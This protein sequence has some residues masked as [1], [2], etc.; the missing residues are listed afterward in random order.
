LGKA[1]TY[2]RMW[3]LKLATL[4]TIRA[5]CVIDVGSRHFDFTSLKGT[6][7]ELVLAPLDFKFTFCQ[8]ATAPCDGQKTS[9]C[10]F[11][12]TRHRN[13]ALW[14]AAK[15]WSA[16]DGKV[17]VLMY[18]EPFCHTNI[19]FECVARDTPTFVSI[20][21]PWDGQYEALIQ[22]PSSVC[23]QPAACCIPATYASSRRSSD[24]KISVMQAEEQTGNWFDEDFEGKGQSLL[25][26]KS[27]D[28]CFT[29]SSSTCTS[30]IYR[31]APT[32]CF[33]KTPDWTLLKGGPIGEASQTAWLSRADGSVV[34]TQ[35]LG[36]AGICVIVD[37][38]K[39]DF[40]PNATLW[41][42]PKSC[43]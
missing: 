29:F 13:I 42:V 7:I 26:S 31:P 5:Q 39:F 23:G 8:A 6:Q 3:V 37:G 28:R 1:Y 27:H 43:L 41:D 34:V 40:R 19:T 35:S 32:Q 18:G 20:D 2:L 12:G 38:S 21:E 14:S 16:T 10:Q 24:G 25:C 17:S 11:D 4:L 33:G 15:N 30:E 22:V 36:E 9:L